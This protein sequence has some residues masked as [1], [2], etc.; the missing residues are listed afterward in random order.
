M[1]GGERQAVGNAASG[2][3]RRPYFSPAVFEPIDSNRWEL[4][5]FFFT[6]TFNDG[7]IIPVSV[8]I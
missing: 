2:L 5:N 7:E 6:R 8:L 1:F 3:C 4:P